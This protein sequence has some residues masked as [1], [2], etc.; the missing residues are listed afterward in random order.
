MD[1]TTDPKIRSFLPVPRDSHSPIQNLPFG[2]FRR[3]G[4]G[5]PRVG[6]RVGDVVVDLAALAKAG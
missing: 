6:T 5:S 2:V 3:R 4:R 1:P